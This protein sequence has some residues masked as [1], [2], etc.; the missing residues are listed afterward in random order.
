MLGANSQ[1]EDWIR[2]S[3]LICAI[4]LPNA[5]WLT[6]YTNWGICYHNIKMNESFECW[7][8]NT[9]FVKSAIQYVKVHM[10]KLLQTHRFQWTY[11]RI[12]IV[13]AINKQIMNMGTFSSMCLVINQIIVWWF[14]VKRLDPTT[15]WE[16]ILWELCII[17]KY[18]W[19]EYGCK[20][21]NIKYIFYCQDKKLRFFL[22]AILWEN[23]I[24]Y[25][26]WINKQSFKFCDL[27]WP[28]VIAWI[29]RQP[30][31]EG[32]GIIVYEHTFSFKDLQ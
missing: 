2:E 15:I 17:I 6:S 14:F 13:L 10:N 29:K 7:Y 22:H 32:E 19:F 20:S 28:M 25:E 21:K 31:C 8:M 30:I 5:N 9:S 4:G 27:F 12:I 23:I 16:F 3:T 11:D 1:V 26:E 18:Y 24:A